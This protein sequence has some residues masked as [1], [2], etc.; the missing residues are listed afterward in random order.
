MAYISAEEVKQIREKI[1]KEFK[2]FKF[3]ITREHSMT[4]NVDI[5][6]GNIDFYESLVD[7]DYY[8]K[9]KLYIQ[10]NEYHIDRDFEG[11]AKEMLLK[12]QKIITGIKS[13]YDRN[14]GDMGADYPDYN[15]FYN[16][17]IGRWDRPYKLQLQELQAQGV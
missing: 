5:L 13:C 1:K 8:K 14:F 15:Y 10:V 11:I 7:K 3:S 6:E 9:D 12:I 16:I 4:V 17:S 2:N